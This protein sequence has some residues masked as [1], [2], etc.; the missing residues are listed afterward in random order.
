ML[1]VKKTLTKILTNLKSPIIVDYYTSP[2]K[3]FP[4]AT[5][6]SV[7]AEGW[8]ARTISGY[9]PIGVLQGTP[10]TYGRLIAQVALNYGTYGNKFLGFVFNTYSSALTD[11]IMIP[12][13]YI[14]NDLL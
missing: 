11:T 2:S 6:T 5:A 4:S 7:Y 1:N 12:V 10:N 3:S 9:T 8:E 14:R 13:L